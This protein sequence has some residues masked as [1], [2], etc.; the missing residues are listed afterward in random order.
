MASEVQ[1][2]EKKINAFWPRKNRGM[3]K[4]LRTCGLE[5]V[6][7]SGKVVPAKT[8]P[9]ELCQC[10][11]RCDEK[12]PMEIRGK[13]FEEFYNITEHAR[14]NEF[15]MAHIKT[16]AVQR[17]STELK[18]PGRNQRRVS[19]K[20]Q[21]PLPTMTSPPL[22]PGPS[23]PDVKLVEVCQKAF[24][25]AF[26]ITEKRVRIQREKLIS[27][28]LQSKMP[29]L[30]AVSTQPDFSAHQII[31]TMVTIPLET[32][33]PESQYVVQRRQVKIG[34]IGEVGLWRDEPVFESVK[35]KSE[36][37]LSHPLLSLT[38]KQ[39]EILKT[40]DDEIALVDNFFINQLWKPEYINKAA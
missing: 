39:R 22:Q 28:V 8:Q 25:N 18:I 2:S 40:H 38:P 36:V 20:Y 31:P 9:D 19:C 14:Q 37:D 32:E 30:P 34:Q 15:L 4:R 1:H 7:R 29:R 10:P 17:R 16:R 13:L 35:P 21:I 3:Q 27:R 23:P 5:Y 12:V 24:M 6:S 26:A 33:I 11:Q